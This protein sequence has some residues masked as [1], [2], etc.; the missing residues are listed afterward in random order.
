MS[1][2]YFDND[3]RLDL[4]FPFRT[5][6]SK[7]PQ[8]MPAHGHSQIEFMYFYTTDGCDY[9]CHGDKYRIRP[10]DVVVANS[11]EIHECL[12]FG[13]NTS[14]CCLITDIPMPHGYENLVF[15]NIYN[16][17]RI[18]Y[19]FDKIKQAD[20]NLINYNHI[21]MSCIYELFA[22]LLELTPEEQYSTH[23]KKLHLSKIKKVFEYINTN[24]A[25][26][27]KMNDLADIMYLSNNRFYHVF[28][29]TTGLSPTEYISKLRMS[30]ACE[31]LANSNTNITLIAEQC[32]Y[33]ST[34]YFSKR[35]KEINKITP[36]EYR[37]IN[38]NKT[39]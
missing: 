31:M 19:I 16:D 9:T 21:I 3:M 36:Y 18:T 37:Q 24:I 11:Y 28:K 33:C 27:I 8:R 38:R 5:T 13:T 22:V 34:S 32:G 10:N 30:K 6:F 25:N 14:V 35:F 26:E 23:N 4:K 17:K 20:K 39:N 29:E 1:L 7:R 2:V 15:S 12:D